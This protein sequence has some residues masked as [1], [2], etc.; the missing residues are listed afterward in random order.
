MYFRSAL[1]S[2][3]LKF[4]AFQLNFDGKIHD[5]PRGP[6]HFASSMLNKK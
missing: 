4:N 2:V 6:F 5:A 3:F 1:G